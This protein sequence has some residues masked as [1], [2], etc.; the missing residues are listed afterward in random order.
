MSFEILIVDDCST[1]G[2]ESVIAA[3]NNKSG[4][5]V[6]HLR[7]LVNSG[8]QAVRNRGILEAKGE[9]IAFLDIDD[10]WLEDKL[11]W[12]MELL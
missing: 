5:I 7:L 1:D 4:S 8:A 10:I 9:W 12:Q 3:V 6:R 2:I 11:E